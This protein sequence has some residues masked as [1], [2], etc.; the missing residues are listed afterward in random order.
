MIRPVDSGRVLSSRR[1][2][3]RWPRDWSSDVCSSDLVAAGQPPMIESRVPTELPPL[4]MLIE[5]LRLNGFDLGRLRLESHARSEGM[6]FELLEVEG[7]SLKLN[8]HG[9]WI[10]RQAQ[11]VTEFEGRLSTERLSDLLDVLGLETRLDSALS[12]VSLRGSWPGAPSDFVLARLDGQLELAMHNGRILDAQPGAGR[13]IG[14]ISLSAVPRRLMLDF[15]DVF[16]QGLS[17]DRIEGGFDLEKGV[18][19]TG[20]LVLKSPSASITVTGQTDLGAQTYNQIIR[21]EPSAGATLPVTGGPAG[22]PAGA[23]ARTLLG[24]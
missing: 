4:H 9:R 7:P 24:R 23:R 22:G 20:G 6:E 13:L 19:T 3:T 2:H 5:S 16:G 14:L 12:E 10:V 21:V 18:A 17:F 8:G 11:P 15:R 1:R